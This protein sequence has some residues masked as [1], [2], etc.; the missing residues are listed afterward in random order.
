MGL[1]VGAGTAVAE[2]GHDGWL[3]YARLSAPAQA[4][5]GIVLPETLVAGNPRQVTGTAAAELADGIERMTGRRPAVGTALP[6]GG[7]SST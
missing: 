4:Q 7:V 1:A 5:L 2:T 3:R 6:P